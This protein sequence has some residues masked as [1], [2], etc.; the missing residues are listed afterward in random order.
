MLLWSY[1][2]LLAP[3]PTTLS[4]TTP[5]RLHVSD[6]VRNPDEILSMPFSDRLFFS[7]SDWSHF[8]VIAFTLNRCLVLMRDFTNSR[9]W[10]ISFF[11]ACSRCEISHILGRE[12]FPFFSWHG[13]GDR[14]S[15]LPAE[16]HHVLPSTPM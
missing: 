5:D 14:T 9:A 11:C 4:H 13:G 6:Y 1:I 3:D 12:E 2:T 16:K 15:D 7:V 8:A 10:G